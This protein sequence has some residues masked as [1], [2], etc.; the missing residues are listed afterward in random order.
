MDAVCEGAGVATRYDS[1][2]ID[3]ACSIRIASKSSFSTTS[4]AIL[5]GWRKSTSRCNLLLVSSISR[6]LRC[7][8][9]RKGL[10]DR[11]RRRRPKS[12]S[13]VSTYPSKRSGVT[14]VNFYSWLDCPPF[15]L[16]ISSNWSSARRRESRTSSLAP[17]QRLTKKARPLAET[18]PSDQ[19]LNY[20]LV[21]HLRTMTAACRRTGRLLLRNL[22]DHR[23]RRQHQAAD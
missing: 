23:F 9:A 6:P 11:C 4:R 22:T 20:R 14:F 7:L 5:S 8:S 12:E 3:P 19:S 21:I 10:P 13:V 2:S 18:G 17:R 15:R 1:S 16:I